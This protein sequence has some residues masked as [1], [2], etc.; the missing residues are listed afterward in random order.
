MS[1]GGAMEWLAGRRF[2]WSWPPDDC[3]G[4]SR[5]IGQQGAGHVSVWGEMQGRLLPGDSGGSSGQFWQ[6]ALAGSTCAFQEL[7][8]QVRLVAGAW[9]QYVIRNVLL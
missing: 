1:L 8:H 7:C 2:H 3:L 4:R 9:R 6:E 5:V